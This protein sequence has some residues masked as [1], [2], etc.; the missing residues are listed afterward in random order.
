MPLASLNVVATIGSVP[1]RVEGTILKVSRFQPPP[2][3][4]RKRLCGPPADVANC[5]DC[6]CQFSYPPVDF[7]LRVASNGPSRW[8]WRIWI[9]LPENSLGQAMT[10]ANVGGRTAVGPRST[11]SKRSQSLGLM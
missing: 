6:D 10:A 1:T 7:T 5:T 4:R 3:K 11:L 2:L 8:S 9:V